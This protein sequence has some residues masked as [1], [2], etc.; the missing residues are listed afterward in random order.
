MIAVQMD[1][2]R[3]KE[4]LAEIES[5]FELAAENGF[6]TVVLY[7]EDRIKTRSYPFS[8]DQES[9]LPEEIRQIL[10]YATTRHLELIPVVS[11]L[12]HVERFLRH[13]ELADLA[14]TRDGD[15]ARFQFTD[16]QPRAHCLCPSLEESYAF[17]DSYISEVAQ[18]FPSSYFH[19]GLDEA[20][21]M[22]LC[23]LC[24]KRMQEGGLSGLLT[25]HIRHTH[26]LLKSLGKTM[27]I[28]DDMFEYCPGALEEIPRDIVLCCW[29]Y[30]YIAKQLPGHFNNSK[31]ADLFALYDQLGFRY[32]AATNTDVYNVASFTRYASQY[33]PMGFLA[34]IWERSLKQLYALYPLVANAG[35]LWNKLLAD[36]PD[37]RLA[38]AIQQTYQIEDESLIQTVAMI[39]ARKYQPDYNFFSSISQANQTSDQNYYLDKALLACLAE[40]RE[41][42]PLNETM[43]AVLE[44]ELAS[45]CLA[46]EARQLAAQIF[47]HRTGRIRADLAHVKQ[48]LDNCLAQARQI[49]QEQIELWQLLRSGIALDHLLEHHDL[50]LGK[51]G[52]L[53]ELAQTCSFGEAGRLD[54][55]FF[56]PDQTGGARTKI[57]VFYADGS[58]TVIPAASYKYL[59]SQSAYFGLAFPLDPDKAI[60]SCQLTVL[61]YGQAGFCYLEAFNQKGRFV[62]QGIG[63]LA[64]KVSQAQH[65][66]TDDSTWCCLGEADMLAPFAKPELARQEHCMT[67]FMQEDL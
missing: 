56:L 10:D 21:D 8:S 47:D 15:P 63:Q 7:L 24:R 3:Q 5:F 20:W 33:Q 18:L 45:S 42:E 54:I 16:E 61:G 31:K 25:D 59:A 60:R 1:L 62:P 40:G 48:G 27:L 57:V 58:K 9:Y 32:I 22:G 35:L 26:Q 64:G 4:N 11:N 36:Q 67:I 44:Y 65:V 39:L 29:N 49:K 41:I 2:A 17:F 55:S 12:G 53:K 13:P 6:D 52:K 51:L 50:L 14:E 23:Q 43:F 37:Q 28:W 30:S 46:Y 66:L 19:V 34:T 38:Q